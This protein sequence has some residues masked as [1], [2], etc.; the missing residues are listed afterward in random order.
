[1]T[2][3]VGFPDATRSIKDLIARL[4]ADACA[5]VR[6]SSSLRQTFGATEEAFVAEV[7]KIFEIDAV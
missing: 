6:S 2:P 3:Q 5:P 1:M 7:A 4:I